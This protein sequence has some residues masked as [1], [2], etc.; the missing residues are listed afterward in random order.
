MS[1]ADL[2][3]RADID[4]LRAVAVGVV[5]LFHA[6]PARLPGGFVGVD[7][8]FV[9]SGYLI[10]GIILAAHADRRFTFAG[11]YARRIKRLFPALAVVLATLLAAGWFLLYA[12]DYSRLG[13][14]AAAGA[15]FVS[16]VAFWREA[17]YFDVAANL[18]PLLHLWSLGVEEQFYLV[19]PIM[20]IAAARW[21]R[22]PLAAT[23]AIGTVSFLLAIYTVRIDRTPAFYAPWNR[24]WELL[25]GATL[26]CI[27]A[28]AAL[29][30]FLKRLV[31]TPWV[32]NIAAT[33]G[34]LAIAAGVWLID[35][36][37]VFPGLWVMLPV[38]GT[39]LLIAAGSQAWVNRTLLSLRPVVFIGLI[40]YPLYLWH[41]P[42]L[43]LAHILAGDIPA[44]SLRLGL[45]GASV[46]LASL[47]YYFVERPIRFGRRRP[48]TSPHA[49]RPLAVPA[50]ATV[51]TV[52]FAAGAAI[53]NGNGLIDRPVNRNDAAR[54]IDYYD[55]LHK[56]GLAAA[57][58]GE[59]D[60]MD[61]DGGERTSLDPSCTA[62]G[63]AHTIFLWGDSFAQALSL[64]LREAAP[65]DT[66]VA[67][68]AT[69][70]C[71][72]EIEN[73]DLSV[74][75][76]RCEKANVLAMQTI[77]RLRPDVVVIAQS[78]GHATTDWPKVVARTLDLG[79][80]HV[81]VVG[82]FPVWQPSLPRV[83]AEH[84]MEDRVERVGIGLDAGSFQ[85][86]RQMADHLASM[87]HVT[88]LSLLEQLCRS[89]SPDGTDN[90][91]PGHACLAR[92][93]GEDQLDLMA[94]DF[95]HLSP[96]GS[97][98]LGRAIWKDLLTPLLR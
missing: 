60:F 20:L 44:A 36:T 9:I 2:R 89:Q 22:G 78:G 24:F 54:L 15:A 43:S 58:R 80:R 29:D 38:G 28:D 12:D 31:S 35:S 46:V 92:V 93:P 76:R 19:W 40:S 98:Y 71:R 97:S 94:V 41:W 74:K 18:K 55:R 5:L 57:Y 85:I 72:P 62:A 14:H 10:S 79:A 7:V 91:D 4:G 56:T 75:E 51:M 81:I 26:A 49:R 69:S 6:F 1:Q 11:F 37:R 64:G 82:P 27:E 59:C 68:V 73:F 21:K 42:L 23:L 96:K 25:A 48:S 90:G 63:S 65:P 70:M 17:S 8:F 61:W 84:H 16:N 30:A 53:V 86:D 45:L 47:T 13:R 3:Y 66:A 88:Y 87:P 52:I 77:E 34:A 50:L 67:Q 39:F 33:I 83:Y 32:S 95:G